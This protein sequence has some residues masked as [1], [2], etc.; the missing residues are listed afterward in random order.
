MQ[1]SGM[2]ERLVVQNGETVVEQTIAN[3][4]LTAPDR[5]RAATNVSAARDPISAS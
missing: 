2:D 5:A 4:I 3:M 1:I